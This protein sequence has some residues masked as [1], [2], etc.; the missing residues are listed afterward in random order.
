M[1]LF[2]RKL[3]E[4]SVEPPSKIPV[5]D[6]FIRWGHNSRYWARAVGNGFIFGDFVAGLSENS[7]GEKLSK[8][9]IREYRLIQEAVRREQDSR[10]EEVAREVDEVYKHLPRARDDFPYI[11]RKR[12][13]AHEIGQSRNGNTLVLGYRD[14]NGR[15]WTLQAI[16]PMELRDSTQED[17][18]KV[19]FIL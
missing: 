7:F 12:V 14:V 8:E 9:D 2:Y 1:D 16:G 4:F 3:G 10:W 18:G 5:G 6:R 11:A 13:R 15:L 19:V 17:A